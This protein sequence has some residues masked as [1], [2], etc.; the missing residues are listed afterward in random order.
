MLK[1]SSCGA[2]CWRHRALRLDIRPSE[3]AA[4]VRARCSGCHSHTSVSPS[5]Q[6]DWWLEEHGLIMEKPSFPLP[7]GKYMV[8]GDREVT[9]ELTVT[10]DNKWALKQGVWG[11]HLFRTEVVFPPRCCFK[12]SLCRHPARCHAFALPLRP[13]HAGRRRVAG[14]RNAGARQSRCAPACRAL[15]RCCSTHRLQ[16]HSP[17]PRAPS[18]LTWTAASKHTRCILCV[19]VRGG[20]RAVISTR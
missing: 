19:C 8:T 17:A 4:C 20:R 1:C 5:P 15:I 13:L 14:G 6:S 12:A 10:E 9:T 16:A 2:G 11:R 3:A 18:C 7:A